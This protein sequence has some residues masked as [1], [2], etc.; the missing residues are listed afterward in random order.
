MKKT[1]SG[2]KKMG[3]HKRLTACTSR[4]KHIGHCHVPSHLSTY[5]VA[6]TYK[7]ISWA[8]PFVFPQQCTHYLLEKV[9]RFKR[10]NKILVN[11]KIYDRHRKITHYTTSQCNVSTFCTHNSTFKNHYCY[12]LATS[13]IYY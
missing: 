6:S 5:V 13:S 11:R 10:A 12:S 8:M 7:H 3:C 4:L 1:R 2:Y 9:K